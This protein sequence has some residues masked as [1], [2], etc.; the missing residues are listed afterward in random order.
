M[1]HGSVAF[2]CTDSRKRKTS[3]TVQLSTHTVKKFGC[4]EFGDLLAYGILF[5][6]EKKS[7][8]DRTV[9]KINIFDMSDLGRILNGLHLF[10]R[11]DLIYDTPLFPKYLVSPVI[12]IVAIQ[13]HR[14]F[15]IHL[16]EVIIEI[17]IIFYRDPGMP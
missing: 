4:L 1:H 11:I 3:E 14:R 12:D 7:G 6:K 5:H 9:I 8:K 17:I 16:L 2:P 15:Q 10:G 13:K